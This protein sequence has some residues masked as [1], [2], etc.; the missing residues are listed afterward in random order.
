L[1]I[2]FNDGVA[3]LLS[4]TKTDS[5][6]GVLFFGFT[7]SNAVITAVTIS[8]G[9]TTGSRDVFGIDDV[10]FAAATATTPLPAALPLFATGLGV[11]LGWRRKR[12][13]AA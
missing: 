6:G 2:S 8:E 13:L 10:R 3:Q 7:D 11:L 5:T 4:I 9:A 1:T 12:K